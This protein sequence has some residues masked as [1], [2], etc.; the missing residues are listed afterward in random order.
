MPAPPL[1]DSLNYFNLLAQNPNT[2]KHVSCSGTC[3]NQCLKICTGNA[4]PYKGW[5]SVESLPPSNSGN[6]LSSC[7]CSVNA[8][9]AVHVVLSFI[10]PNLK[11]DLFL[12]LKGDHG[13]V[14]SF[15]LVVI[16]SFNKYSSDYHVTET[17]KKLEFQTPGEFD[18]QRKDA[19][20]RRIRQVIVNQCVLA[21]CVSE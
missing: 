18:S 1:S 3:K 8:L 21:F 7:S 14:F 4:F 15:V 12:K 17:T 10:A 9:L 16:D 20:V 6:T 13:F 2:P 5:F 19:N 11:L